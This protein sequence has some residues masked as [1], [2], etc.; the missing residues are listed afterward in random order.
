LLNTLYVS[1]QGAYLR[2]EG[3]TVV[4]EKEKQQ[5]LQL[6]IHTIGGI[7]CFGNVSCSPFLLGFCAERNVAISFLREPLK[8]H[9]FGYVSS[10]SLVSGF[11]IQKLL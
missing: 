9:F 8:T 3:E 4:V 6:P 7:V 10:P 1:S 2:K 5:V 11:P